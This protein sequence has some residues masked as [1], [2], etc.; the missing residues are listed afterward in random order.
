MVLSLIIISGL[1]LLFCLFMLAVWNRLSTYEYIVRQRH[2]QDNKDS[3]KPA[4]AAEVATPSDELLKVD[5]QQD[6]LNGRVCHRH[7]LYAFGPCRTQTV[8]GI[9]AT[10]TLSWTGRTHPVLP[11][12]LRQCKSATSVL[13]GSL[14]L[15][16]NLE[17][18]CFKLHNWRSLTS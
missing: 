13:A 5:E 12:G 14:G 17:C 3:R 1:C 16:L 7:C 8:P 6:C 10:P 18:A 9:M 15:F 4:A 11:S 2:R